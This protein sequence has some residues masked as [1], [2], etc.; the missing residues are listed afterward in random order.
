MSDHWDEHNASVD[1]STAA[2]ARSLLD[3]LIEKSRLY[4]S[5]GDYRDLLNF[6]VRLRKFAPFNAMLLHVQ[7]PGLLYAASEQDWRAEFR[8]EAEGRRPAAA[9]PLAVWSGGARV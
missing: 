4:K 2:A 9:H 1:V 8:A 6:V 3:G 5:S 7:K